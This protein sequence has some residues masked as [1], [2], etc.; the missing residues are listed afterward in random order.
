VVRGINSDS[1]GLWRHYQK[2]MAPAL[3]VLE[4]WVTT[5]GYGL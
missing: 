3:P 4:P 1:V 2:E 5:Y